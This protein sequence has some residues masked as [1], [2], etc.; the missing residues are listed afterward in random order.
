MTEAITG[1]WSTDVP[2]E[3]PVIYDALV[4]EVGHAPIPDSD[5]I[6]GR[7]LDDLDQLR[8]QLDEVKGRSIETRAQTGAKVSIGLKK[9]RARLT[10]YLDLPGASEAEQISKNLY[11]RMYVECL[12]L[13]PM[14]VRLP[15]PLRSV[16]GHR[17]EKVKSERKYKHRRGSWG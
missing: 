14:D 6:I 8:K 1:Y 2:L 15:P 16:A 9:I 11:V 5:P 3:P 12:G 17:V 4:T 13:T 10:A 7:L